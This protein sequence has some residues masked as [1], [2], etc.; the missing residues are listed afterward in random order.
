MKSVAIRLGMLVG[1][2]AVLT[3]S[4]AAEG[5]LWIS[6]Y[7]AGED[8]RADGEFADGKV[9]LEEAKAE[10]ALSADA[11]YRMASTLDRLGLTTMALEDYESAE[12]YLQCALH[13]KETKLGEESRHIPV[14]LN[15]LGDLYYLME[16]PDKA[17][18]YYRRALSL[19]ERDQ[20]NVEVSRSLNGMA[21]LHNDREEY[22]QAE[23]LLKRAVGI[24]DEHMRRLHP[25]CATACTN[26]GILYMHLDRLTESQEQLDRARYIQN[27]ALGEA[28]PDVALRLSAEAALKAKLGDNHA[29][30]KLE[31]RAKEIR[32]H[33]KEVNAL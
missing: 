9:L 16:M 19:N 33:F 13:L 29:A 14:T 30:A 18:T 28:H 5:N 26:L 20:Q 21:L 1:M 3:H 27:K 10:T 8:N 11:A 17:E 15:T 24:H 25:Y 4:A 12:Q 2:I 31:K 7:Y 32:K 6:Y 22:V 23:E